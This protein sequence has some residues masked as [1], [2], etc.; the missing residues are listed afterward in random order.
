MKS[1]I[2]AIVEPWVAIIHEVHIYLCA[3]SALDSGANKFPSLLKLVQK[4]GNHGGGREAENEFSQ[5]CFVINRKI[6][7]I[8]IVEMGSDSRQNRA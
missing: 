7:E 3:S 1:N 8:L 6:G 4:S 2:I 5:K